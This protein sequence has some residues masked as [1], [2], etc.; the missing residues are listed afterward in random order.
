MS[1]ELGNPLEGNR[2]FENRE[3]SLENM[4]GYSE[5][6]TQVAW[7]IAE[8]IHDSEGKD[9]AL[10]LPSR[11]AIPIFVGAMLAFANE[12]SL[13]EF[14][15]GNVF[16]LP[17]LSCF[18]YVRKEIGE[19]P[20]EG[21]VR[22]LIFP[23]TADIDLTGLGFDS[24][25]KRMSDEV[26]ASMRRFGARA[27]TEFFKPLGE[28]TRS[29]LKTFLSFLETVEGRRGI[30]NFISNFPQVDKMLAIDTVISGQASWT[31]LDE[32]EKEGRYISSGRIDPILVVDEDGK[33]LKKSFRS[34][35]DQR[36]DDSI[37]VSRILTEDRGAA[38]EGVAALVYPGLIVKFGEEHK[39][40]YPLF[41][42]WHDI[43]LVYKEKYLGVLNSFFDTINS[44]IRGASQNEVL[45]K[46]D[47]FCDRLIQ[48]RVLKGGEDLIGKEFK[49]KPSIARVRETSS[50]VM[51]LY[52]SDEV[53]RQI[54][55]AIIKR[56][57]Q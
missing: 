26:L 13:K 54:M 18:D 1:I 57:T 24:R 51:Q 41:G 16:E 52:F 38:L 20:T 43:P 6:C 5:M 37:R 33:K 19:I 31:I 46:R 30:N 34:F 45:E 36:P 14:K 7:R 55:S 28:R 35:V 11:G 10:L 29:E 17:L 32:L 53:V 23:F 2:K 27:I 4:R 42:S 3:F 56:Q 8:K 44:I 15:L 49:I 25:I 48:S 39:G 50:H 22:V 21:K 40:I 9:I 47:I 12:P